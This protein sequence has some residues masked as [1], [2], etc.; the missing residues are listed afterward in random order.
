M[1][2]SLG[3]LQLD[4]INVVARTQFLVVFSRLGAYDVSRLQR[5]TGPGGDLFE[6]WGHAAALLPMAHHRLFRWRMDQHGPYDR[7]S[8]YH[9]RREAWRGEHADYI[10]AILEEVRDRGPLRASQLTDPRRRDGE[11]WERRSVGRQA[12]EWLFAKGEVA[13]WRTANF[14]RVYDLPERV[15]PHDVLA[16]PTPPV[17]EAHR[18]LLALAAASLGVATVG[19]LADYYWIMPSDARERVAE[20]VE[21][22]EVVEVAVEGWREPGYCRPSA[23][24]RPPTRSHATLLSPFDSLICR[25]DRTRRL[26]GFDYRIE[27][28]VPEPARQYGYYVLPLLSGDELVARLDLKADRKSSKLRVFG[29]YLEPGVDQATATSAAAAELDALRGWLGLGEIAVGERGGLAPSLRA[30]IG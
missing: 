4:A 1:V 11:W 2:E 15:I 30:A 17:E 29:A 22:G 8:I 18:R 12:L 3:T 25:R 28:Y 20:L 14:E 5:L 9:A 19:D 16:Q 6:Y 21:S 24:P 7:S 13:A 27:V 10:A 23:H 26:F